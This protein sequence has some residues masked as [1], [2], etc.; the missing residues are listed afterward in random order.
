MG[1][2]QRAA[3]QGPSADPPFSCQVS[4][5]EPPRLTVT[6]EAIPFVETDVFD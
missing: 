1:S 3:V 5:E 2:A 4:Y 6:S